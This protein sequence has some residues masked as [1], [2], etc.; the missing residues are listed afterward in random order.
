[1]DLNRCPSPSALH[2]FVLEIEMEVR[3]QPPTSHSTSLP[4]SLLPRFGIGKE[5]SFRLFISSQMN[6]AHLANV[7]FLYFIS[8]I[9][10]GRQYKIVIYSALVLHTFYTIFKTQYWISLRIHVVLSSVQGHG[11]VFSSSFSRT[12]LLTPIFAEHHHVAALISPR[13][14]C[15]QE[16]LCCVY[17]K[18]VPALVSRFKV[19]SGP[20]HTTVAQ[21]TASVYSQRGSSSPASW[22][23]CSLS[24]TYTRTHA[25]RATARTAAHTRIQPHLKWL[26]KKYTDM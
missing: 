11:R 16:P 18:Q 24:H 7:F 19:V 17:S 9:K 13:A 12:V 26:R 20:L 14:A 1:M 15:S 25:Q 6:L 10:P 5:N 8:I 23:D 3:N 4:R 21:L 2:F 22:L